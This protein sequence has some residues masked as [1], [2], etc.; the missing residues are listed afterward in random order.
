M[1]NRLLT[2]LLACIMLISAAAMSGCGNDESLEQTQQT[3]SAAGEAADEEAALPEETGKSKIERVR[4]LMEKMLAEKEAEAAAAPSESPSP[5]P[6]P[7]PTPAPEE[8]GNLSGPGYMLYVNTST[9]VVGAFRADENGDYTDLVRAMVCSPGAGGGTPHGDFNTSQ[10]MRWGQLMGGVWGQYCTRI[11]GGVLFHSVP[12]RSASADTL[13]W[14]KYNKLGSPASAGC[15]RMTVADAKWIYDNCALGTRV[16][17]SSKSYGGMPSSVG[18]ITLAAGSKWDPTDPNYPGGNPT[19]T[20]K[21]SAKPTPT[22]TPT[23][24]P[25]PVP[26]EPTPTPAEE[27]P[28]PPPEEEEPTPSPEE[29]GGEDVSE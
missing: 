14:E 4:E 23:P 21:P 8:E 13:Y 28:T 20:P 27:E 10:K 25:T 22:P 19:V 9:C 7:S 15:I 6:S 3:A 11:V 29:T 5:S 2:A 16:V 26:E 12:Y 18:H 1:K 24:A 17:I